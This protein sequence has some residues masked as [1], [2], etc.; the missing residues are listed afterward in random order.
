M[1]AH[2]DMNMDMGMDT[3]MGSSPSPSNESSS[4]AMGMQMT[5]FTATSTP[6]YSNAWTPSST[7]AYAGTCIFL[8]LL[9]LLFRFLLSVKS[10]MESR[11]REQNLNRR[12]IVTADPKELRGNNQANQDADRRVENG[13]ALPAG[14]VGKNAA[15]LTINGLDEN[16]RMVE[17]A[18][19]EGAEPSGSAIQPFRLSV[20]LVRAAV[21]TVLVG[22][23]YLL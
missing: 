13:P 17:R 4:T 14:F 3:D 8:I 1:V 23:A 21:V 18:R 7:G 9:A 12:F 5:F 20:D 10:Q 15:V 22:V 6:L 16:V 19:G 11:W 2:G